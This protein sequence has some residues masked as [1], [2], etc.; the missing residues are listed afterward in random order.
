MLFIRGFEFRFHRLTVEKQISRF[1]NLYE[2]ISLQKNKAKS[3]IK[4]TTL[5]SIKLKFNRVD[6]E[7]KNSGSKLIVS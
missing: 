3:E 2:R 5:Q 4:P 1:H 6:Y 7:L